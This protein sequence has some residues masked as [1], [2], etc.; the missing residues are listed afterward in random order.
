MVLTPLFLSGISGS[1]YTRKMVALL[2]YRRIPYRLISSATGVK[3]LPSSK[4]P[5]LPTF[6][7]PGPTNDLEAVTDSTPL[8]RRFE[9]D[10]S[11]RSVIPSDPSL[12]LIDALLE[13]FADEW[14]TKAMFHYRWNFKS[15]I[16]KAGRI[17]ACLWKIEPLDDTSLE[18]MTHAVTERQV[19]R[20]SMVGSNATTGSAIEEGYL[21][22]LLALEE[23]LRHHSFLLGNRP[24]SSDFAMYGQLSQLVQ[25]DPTPMTL[26]VEHAP[27]VCAWVALLEDLSGLDVPDEG[28]WMDA[29]TLPS[30]LVALLHEV[31]RLYVPILLANAMAVSQSKPSFE[32]TVDGKPWK[33]NTFSYQAKCLA[34]LRRDYQ[35][36]DGNARILVDQ[37][38]AGT[39]CAEL[40]K[41]M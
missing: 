1:P 11:G 10:Y 22:V 3:G 29:H 41:A 37:V 7:L 23:N 38:L 31:G 40:F 8:I 32:A 16:E 27:R 15:D 19:K 26:A 18:R 36:L 17:L 2:R 5:L 34:W 24:S 21:R 39:G 13:D 6:Y 4:P 25:F 12:A 30:S 33:Q 9:T 35:A 14:L 28:G 20:L